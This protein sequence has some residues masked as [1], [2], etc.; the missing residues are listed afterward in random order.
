MS[1][2][3]ILFE[4]CFYSEPFLIDIRAMRTVATIFSMILALAFSPR[5]WSEE[6]EGPPD[7]PDEVTADAEGPP[8]VVRLDLKT[9][10][11]RALANSRK[12]EAEKHKLAAIEARAGQIWWAPFSLSSIDG[13]FSMVPDRC[14]DTS[15]L[16]TNGT[17]EGC[18]NQEV[19]DDDKDWQDESWGPT[20]Q[21][22]I[23]G[24]I[25]VSIPS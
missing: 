20:F 8:N 7:Q 14:I 2:G 19:G 9:C 15:A 24:V 18:G 16:A 4:N 6:Q 11:E 5:V 13:A 10:T 21:L 1:V 23:K 22:N 17:I 25:P 12:L 3:N